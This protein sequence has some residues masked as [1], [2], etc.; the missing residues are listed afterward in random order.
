MA[1]SPMVAPIQGLPLPVELDLV[2]PAEALVVGANL[3]PRHQVRGAGEAGHLCADLGDE[4][5][6]GDPADPRDFIERVHLVGKRGEQLLDPAGQLIDL[7]AERVDAVQ[8]H[9]QQVAVVGA[10]VPGER[11]GQDAELGAHPA[12]RQLREYLRVAFAGDQRGQHVPAGD[13]E[14]VGSHHAQLDLGV[15]QQL[16]H[17]LLLAGPLV[18]EGAP[19]AGEVPQLPLPRRRHEAWPQHAPLGQ[20]GQPD[21]VLLSVLGRPGTCL[22]SRAF[23]SQHSHCSSSR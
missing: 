9:L 3:A 12:L 14:D 13:S 22:T 7:G 10:E 23:T 20:L 5:L 11:L 18:G 19:V 21:G 4:L 1:A 2:L 8:H 6:R 16:L 17:A 15:L